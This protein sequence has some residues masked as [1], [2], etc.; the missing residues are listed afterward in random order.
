MK[1][2]TKNLA[3][4]IKIILLLRIVVNSKN[5]DILIAN[6]VRIKWI[7][8]GK[9]NKRT[10][11]QVKLNHYLGI[12]EAQI[13]IGLKNDLR[14]YSKFFVV[15]SQMINLVYLFNTSYFFCYKYYY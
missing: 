10:N 3:I 1:D 8:K 12:L 4:M 9:K 11:Q 13:S 5:L 15:E 14:I 2:M 7:L 6:M